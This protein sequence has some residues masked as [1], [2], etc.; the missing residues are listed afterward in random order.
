MSPAGGNETHEQHVKSCLSFGAQAAATIPF[1]ERG[2]DAEI[3][4]CKQD[5]SFKGGIATIRRDVTL[6]DTYK[7]PNQDLCFLHPNDTALIR[8]RAADAPDPWMHL[9]GKSG[10]CKGKDGY[11]FNQEE[12]QAN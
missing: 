3:N 8:P 5:P 1:S 11:L 6:Y 9:I 4:N 12:A 10:E 2:L 7:D